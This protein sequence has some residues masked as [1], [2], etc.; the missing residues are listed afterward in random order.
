MGH[1]G[2]SYMGLAFLLL[3]LI[4]NILWASRKPQGYTPQNENRLLRCFERVGEAL[5][6]F[7]VL[8][9]SD[10]NWHGYGA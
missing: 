2:F 3:M 4:P 8:C 10:L 5:I 7:C 1:F 9:F 6:C